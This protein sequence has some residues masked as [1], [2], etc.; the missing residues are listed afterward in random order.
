MALLEDDATQKILQQALQGQP[1]GTIA[2]VGGLAFSLLPGQKRRVKIGADLVANCGFLSIP[3]SI[4]DT[5]DFTGPNPDA[6]SAI[7][8]A[9][10]S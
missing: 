7:D 4:E 9:F 3:R 10:K 5:V 6:D 2:S 8:F 1:Q